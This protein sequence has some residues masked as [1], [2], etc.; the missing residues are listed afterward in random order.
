MAKMKDMKSPD[1]EAQFVQVRGTRGSIKG[2]K[3]SS[4]KFSSNI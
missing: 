2:N 3:N 1:H 4:V